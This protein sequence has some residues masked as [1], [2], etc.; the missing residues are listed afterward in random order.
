MAYTISDTSPGKIKQSAM[1]QNAPQPLEAATEFSST[2]CQN[3]HSTMPVGLRFCR[4]CG[5][6]LG[7]GVAEYTETARFPNAAQGFPTAGGFGMPGGQ[8]APAAVGSLQRRK[9]RMGGMTWIFLAMILFFLTAG[10]VT[11]FIRPNRRI[12]AF[13]GT[14]APEVPRSYFGVDSFDTTDGG[15]TFD[16][17]E[18][19]GSPADKAGLVGGDIITI[20]DGQAVK[21]DD[22]LMELLGK[23]PIGKTVDV[24]YVRDG[25]TNTTKLTTMSK[26]DYDQV[27]KIFRTRPEGRGL[28]GYDSGEVERVAIEGTKLHGV[29]LGQILQ[30]RP[31]DIAGFKDG[32]IVI[33][34]D[35]VPIR[36]EEEL[37]ARVQ[38][39]LPYTTINVTIVRGT[40]QI[41]IPVKI[42]RQ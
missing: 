8:M 22:E 28:L 34:I 20:F 7:E 13:A 11:Q 16:S 26:T 1:S 12:P 32:D 36:T 38:R 42:G 27:I 21:T 10:V 2:S 29:R 17:I 40:D 37:R 18:A 3:C 4:N 31:A 19:P 35:K 30:S 9:K 5:F 24:V 15:V 25:E 39:A 41:E 33:S 14:S 23:T 6:R